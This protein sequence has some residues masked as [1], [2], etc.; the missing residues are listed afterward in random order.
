MR[1][2][3]YSSWLWVRVSR[4]ILALHATRRPITDTSGF[5]TTRAWNVNGRFSWNDCV[6]REKPRPHPLA[7][8]CVLWGLWNSQRMACIDS[9]ML[10]T[11]VASPCQ[12]LRELLA[13]RQRVYAYPWTSPSISGVTHAQFPSVAICSHLK[14]YNDFYIGA[15]FLLLSCINHGVIWP[16]E[17]YIHSLDWS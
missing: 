5:R 7:P 17:N 3:G 10:S 14:C 9:L 4:L 1:S 12:T 2:E 8:T 6:R 16:L 15:S 11:S 13:W